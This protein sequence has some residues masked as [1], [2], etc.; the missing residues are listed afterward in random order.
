MVLRGNSSKQTLSLENWM[1]L[2][3]WSFLPAHFARFAMMFI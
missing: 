1:D 3:C 2:Q